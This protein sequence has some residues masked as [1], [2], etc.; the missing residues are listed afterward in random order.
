MLAT[1]TDVENVSGLDFGNTPNKHVTFLLDYFSTHFET[2]IGRTLT[3]QT[4]IVETLDG[5]GRRW[6]QLST[7]PITAVNTVTENTSTLVEN[8]DFLV[9]PDRGRLRRGNGKT[10]TRWT[11]YL[12]AV[13]VDYDAGYTTIPADVV[14]TVAAA[15]AR[16]WR[17]L[18]AT[19]AVDVADLN[20]KL[21]R[22]EH[23]DTIEYHNLLTETVNQTAF[24]AT[25]M[26]VAAQYQARGVA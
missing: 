23:S 11:G 15:V 6:L 19:C 20:V 2:M 24:T 14:G 21:V 9:Y 10:D 7:W 12:K 26:T 8:I 18:A 4:G 3:H 13:V 5:R 16:T 17:Q 1:Q 22:L 25:E